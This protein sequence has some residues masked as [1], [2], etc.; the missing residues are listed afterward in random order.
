MTR[1]RVLCGLLLL[2]A[3]LVCGAGWLVLASGPR[4]TRARFQQVKEGMSRE[5]VIRM[6]GRPTEDYSR[7]H[8][9]PAHGYIH[10][11]W[12]CDDGGLNIVFD[13]AD[14]VVAFQVSELDPPTLTE[15]IRRWLGL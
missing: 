3:V 9:R 13:D 8:D 10:E 7:H 4:A 5:E 11:R 14:R 6:V 1:R 2:S 15:R 12:L